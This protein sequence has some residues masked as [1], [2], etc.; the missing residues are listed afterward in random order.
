MNYGAD[1]F[2]TKLMEVALSRWLWNAQW[3]EPLYHQVSF[4]LLTRGEMRPGSFEYEN[5][6]RLQKRGYALQRMNS[7]T[8]K[9]RFP[10]WAAENY[11][12]GY[13]NPNAAQE[14][15]DGKLWKNL[16]HN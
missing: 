9:V 13:Y 1:E 14:K 5:F 8:L 4:L 15:V 6:V 7:A 12:D 3:Q 10:A 16:S 11:V 2:Y